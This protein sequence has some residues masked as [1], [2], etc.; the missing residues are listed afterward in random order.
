MTDPL[1]NISGDEALRI[2]RALCAADAKIRAR[3][4]TEIEKVLTQ[5]DRDDVADE[6]FFDSDALDV[7]ELRD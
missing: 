3:I 1:D 2:L 5:V 6:V 4:L 7:E